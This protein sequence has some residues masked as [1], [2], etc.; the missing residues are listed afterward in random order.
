[1]NTDVSDNLNQ[2]SK[3][4]PESKPAYRNTAVTI[5]GAQPEYKGPIAELMYSSGADM[6][7]YVYKTDQA[8]PLDYIRSEFKSKRGLCSHRLLTVAVSDGNVVGTGTFYDGKDYQKMSGGAALNLL[9]FYGFKSLPRL[10]RAMDSMKLMKPPKDDELYL[11]NFGVDPQLRG[12]GIGSQM[13][14]HKINEARQQ[15]YRIVSLDVSTENPK[16]EALY[17]RLG[18][19]VTDSKSMTGRDGHTYACKKMEYFL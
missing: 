7:D 8:H 10:R 6:Y 9:R 14:Q 13:L 4:K 2:H 19:A 12:S 18:F 15:G 11:A 5:R 17:H 3:Q 16:A 1:M